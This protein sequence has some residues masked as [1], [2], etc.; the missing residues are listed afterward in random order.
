MTMRKL[1]LVSALVALGIE[2]LCILMMM[3]GGVFFG[4]LANVGIA[5]LRPS[6]YLSNLIL[7][8]GG[9][10]FAVVPIFFQFFIPTLWLLARKYGRRAA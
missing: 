1:M 9:F 2:A 5:L 4:P 8:D 7:G 3:S 10:M 6:L